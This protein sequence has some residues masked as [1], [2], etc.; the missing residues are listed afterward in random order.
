MRSPRLGP[1][2]AATVLGGTAAGFPIHGKT[3]A[4]PLLAPA[5]RAPLVVGVP[6]K[7]RRRPERTQWALA[8]YSVG[9]RR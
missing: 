4:T 9:G 2:G 7:D 5:L 8:V 6:A 3:S 1:S